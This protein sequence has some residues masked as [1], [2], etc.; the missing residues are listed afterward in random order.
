MMRASLS[1][2][3]RYCWLLSSTAMK[4]ILNSGRMIRVVHS[5]ETRR[6]RLDS[7]TTKVPRLDRVPVPDRN[8]APAS[9]TLQV[10]ASSASQ[11][12]ATIEHPIEP[13]EINTAKTVSADDNPLVRQVPAA[14]VDDGSYKSVKNAHDDGETSRVIAAGP[15]SQIILESHGCGR[16]W[17]QALGQEDEKEVEEL[18]NK[19]HALRNRITRRRLST[20]EQ[21]IGDELQSTVERFEEARL[22]LLELGVEDFE[23]KEAHGNRS[24]G[25]S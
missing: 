18:E 3:P 8:K 12:D 15:R 17:Q 14:A 23:N 22:S 13:L 21:Q 11:S 10:S 25:A 9:G 7:K 4:S 24:D 2:V 20:R 1:T 16:L 6:H 19:I 5:S